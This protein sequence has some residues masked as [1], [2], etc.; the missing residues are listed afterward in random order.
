MGLQ[1][2]VFVYRKCANERCL[3]SQ[4]SPHNVDEFFDLDVGSEQLVSKVAYDVGQRA[5]QCHAS[6]CFG[7][8]DTDRE[9]E[10][11]LPAA[12]IVG[13]VCVLCLIALIPRV[14][15]VEVVE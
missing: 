10:L 15:A 9:L 7:G 14:R 2:V 3:N 8:V 1:C 11:L 5:I 6:W 12:V 13:V 4:K